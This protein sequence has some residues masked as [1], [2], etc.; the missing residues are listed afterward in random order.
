MNVILFTQTMRL[1]LPDCFM[2]IAHDRKVRAFKNG[3]LIDLNL[4]RKTIVVEK[5]NS[6]DVISIPRTQHI[7]Y[8]QMTNSKSLE[9]TMREILNVNNCWK[10]V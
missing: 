5:F 10:L 9:D 6:K 3:E 4:A 7:F 2:I 8:S 1:T